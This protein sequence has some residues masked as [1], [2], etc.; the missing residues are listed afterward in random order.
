MTRSVDGKVTTDLKVVNIMLGLMNHAATY[1]SGWCLPRKNDLCNIGEMRTLSR[2]NKNFEEYRKILVKKDANKFE[3]CINATLIKTDKE[4]IL[5]ILPPPELH[6]LIGCV[7]HMQYIG[8]NNAR[9]TEF[10][11]IGESSGFKEMLVKF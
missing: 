7:N 9:F 5:N 1:P 3:N 10:M 6:L 11:L 4:L 2:C 8:P